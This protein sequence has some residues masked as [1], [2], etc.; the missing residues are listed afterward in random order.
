MVPCALPLGCMLAVPVFTATSPSVVPGSTNTYSVA[1]SLTATAPSTWT[2]TSAAQLNVYCDAYMV[3]GDAPSY[4]Q[5]YEVYD[6]S[7][8]LPN[9]KYS[10]M[11]R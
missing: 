5:K 7:L 6:Q 10:I 8:Y 2:G 11:G 1:V 9:Y 4:P 3:L